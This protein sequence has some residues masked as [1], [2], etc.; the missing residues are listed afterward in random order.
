M[1]L[2]LWS[3]GDTSSLAD[4]YQCFRGNCC[5]CSR[6]VGSICNI[7]FKM[8]WSMSRL[9]VNMLIIVFMVSSF[10]IIVYMFLMLNR[11]VLVILLTFIL[12]KSANRCLMFM[13]SIDSCV[14]GMR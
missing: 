14:E 7:S 13:K 4:R 6:V 9:L 5:Y 1:L 11:H 3:T 8:F 2:K 12:C 10:D